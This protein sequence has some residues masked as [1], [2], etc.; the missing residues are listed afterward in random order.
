MTYVTSI[1][2]VHPS[3]L[4]Q[5]TFNLK[6]PLDSPNLAH[7]HRIGMGSHDFS[8]LTLPLSTTWTRPFY[9]LSAPPPPPKVRQSKRTVC[10]EAKGSHWDLVKRVT[11]EEWWPFHPNPKDRHWWNGRAMMYH[12][13][14]ILE[15]RL[16]VQEV[17]G[18]IS[19]GH[20]QLRWIRE[21]FIMRAKAA[22]RLL[23][24]SFPIPKPKSEGFFP[25]PRK[26]LPSRT[27]RN[28][29]PGSRRVVHATPSKWA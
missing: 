8:T 15:T 14:S 18:P 24:S 7:A 4:V 21:H 12:V 20:P 11:S 25:T 23:A 5:W 13:S 28:N 16:P 1:F 6:Q 27:S 29:I 22:F 3:H 9:R 19:K 2:L 10:Q 17:H 26:N